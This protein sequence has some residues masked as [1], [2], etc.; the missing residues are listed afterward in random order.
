M[1]RRV[2]DTTMKPGDAMPHGYASVG[3]FALCI[4]RARRPRRLCLAS[5]AS[6][7]LQNRASTDRRH[8]GAPR[9]LVGAE[10]A[11]PTLAVG[12]WL[13]QEGTDQEEAEEA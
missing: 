10:P 8:L 6:P 7:G 5:V 12:N 9:V 2:V 1:E 3:D 11:R 4:C 13:G